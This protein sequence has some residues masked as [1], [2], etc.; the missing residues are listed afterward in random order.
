MADDAQTLD[1]WR[2][3]DW[4]RSVQ[5]KMLAAADEESVSLRAS[6][7]EAYTQMHATMA[8]RPHAWHL[9]L[10]VE[11][12]NALDTHTRFED[13][14]A[15]HEQATRDAL[16]IS[17][18]VRYASFLIASFAATSRVAV[19][20]DVRNARLSNEHGQPTNLDGVLRAWTGLEEPVPIA[21]NGTYLDAAR[22]AS[23]HIDDTSALD[24]D[25]VRSALRALYGRCAWHVNESSAVWD[26]YLVFEKAF[27]DADPRDEARVEMVRQVFLARLQVPHRSL[28]HTFE[29]FSTFVSMYLPAEAYEET[30]ASANKLY[31][32]ALHV[33]EERSKY[34]DRIAKADATWEDWDVYL[35]WEMHKVKSMRVAKDKALLATEEELAATLYRRALHQFGFFPQSKDASM[36]AAYV[37]QPPTFAFEKAWKAKKGRKSHKMQ[38]REAQEA[39]VEARTRMFAAESLWLAYVGLLNT[40]KA[41]A[42]GVLDACHAAVRSVPPSGKL[43]AFYMRAQVRFLKPKDYV[44]E[45]YQRVVQSGTVAQVGGGAALVALL[46]AHVDCVRTYAALEA[47]L[48]QHIPPE[49]VVLALDLDQFMALYEILLE[50]LGQVGALPEAERDAS[51]TLERYTVDWVERAL[52]AIAQQGGADAAASLYPLAENVVENTL[53]QHSLNPDAYLFAAQFFARHDNEKRARQTFKG[54]AAKHGMVNKLPLL[55]AWVEFEHH[56]GLLQ[57][58]DFAEARTKVEQDRVW[59]SYYKQ[60]Q[61]YQ[62]VQPETTPSQ[63]AP[64]RKADAASQEA[65]PKKGRIEDAETPSRDREFS[66][67]LVAGLSTHTTDADLAAFFRES[68]VICDMVGPR[69]VEAYTSDGAP[70]SAALVEFTDRAMVQAAKTRDLKRLHDFEVHIALSYECTLYVTNFGPDTD[71]ALLRERFAKYGA[72]FDVRWP[73]RKFAQSRRFCYVQYTTPAAALAALAEHGQ[74]WQPEHPLQVFLSNPAHKKERSDADANE[75]EL[76]MTGLPRSATADDVRAF[77]AVHAPVQDVR[78]PLLPNGKSRGIAFINFA[79][80]LDARR[81]MQATNST[82]LKG[83]LVAVMLADAGRKRTQRASQRDDDTRARTV[84]ICG[85]PGDAQEALIQQAMEKALGPGTV[86]RIFWTP[87]RHALDATDADALV[88]FADVETA[89][90]AAL[91]AGITYADTHPLTLEPHAATLLPTVKGPSA[92]RAR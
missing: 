43:W 53:V 9:L 34:E 16:D 87:S 50:A 84:R 89:G 36:D 54:G 44:L 25:S 37:C 68:G 71:D 15:M 57:D 76:Y 32:A 2:F 33:W 27:L 69:P 92:F 82:K 91:G 55:Q 90:K 26:M 10:S 72:I 59:R 61:Q 42:S 14:L 62:V 29:Q 20:V 73:S 24:E 4:V 22:L 5:R 19:P 23:L 65:P 31:V 46:Q 49:D 38:E 75:R 18:Y 83:S 77:F 52:R 35:S 21:Q 88:E 8:L 60:M 81:A 48:A 66:S 41:E 56:R 63:P 64:K 74:Y 1:P 79:S 17:L 70:T 11:L 86:R 80:A 40:P 85:L 13:V 51:L 28:T 58:I 39:R 3:Q 47:A 67:I 45:L 12:A 7:L 78:V 30:M 6:L